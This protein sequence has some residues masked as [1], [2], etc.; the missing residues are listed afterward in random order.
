MIE[1]YNK[2]LTAKMPIIPYASNETI[3]GG[4]NEAL[5]QSVR[6]YVKVNGYPTP[7]QYKKQF[8]NV[9]IK[10][11]IMAIYKDELVTNDYTGDG[12][13]IPITVHLKFDRE[14]LP[15][16]KYEEFVTKVEY[17]NIIL[18][19]EEF[20]KAD[21]GGFQEIIADVE[22]YLLDNYYRS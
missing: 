21:L 13:P 11:T 18:S 17:G 4:V 9:K 8:S 10:H 3:T 22:R 6:D 12:K 20:K 15:A 5:A 16:W 1:H 7:E 14:D 19:A 2:L